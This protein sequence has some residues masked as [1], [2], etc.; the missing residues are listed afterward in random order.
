MDIQKTFGENLRRIRIKFGLS[1]SKFS[2]Q[3]GFS[4]V[5]INRIEKGEENVSLK[6]IWKISNVLNTPISV[7]FS[8]FQGIPYKAVIFDLHYTI[9]RPF[10]SRGVMYQRIF[11]KHGFNAHPREIKKVFSAVWNEYGDNKISEDF[12][13]HYNEKDIEEWWFSFH[14]KMLK[15]LGLKNKNVA[16]V[17]NRD[18]SNQFYGNPQ[19]H[20]MYDD[21]KKIL[22][23]LKKHK[24]KLALAT[25]GY[26]STNQ[27]IKHFR[28]NRYFDYVS[29]SCDVGISKPNPKLYHLIVKRLSL[30][31]EEILCVGDSYPT[32][33]IGAK[34]AGCGAAIIDRKNTEYKKKYD[35]IYLN[36]LTQ[37][38][39]LINFN[40]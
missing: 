17:I 8:P 35:C 27:I 37:V 9:L 24:I 19:I 16:E 29:V 30:K 6:N 28:L 33:I 32:D 3:A 18:I 40:E 15:R 1:Q 21:A 25:N 10:S 26:K 4:P 31:P 5:Y 36:N 13:N 7:L 11:K 34:K 20:R 2:N 22:P 39:N 12:K 14:F 23:F 38:K